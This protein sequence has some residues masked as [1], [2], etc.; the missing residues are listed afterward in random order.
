MRTGINLLLALIMLGGTVVMAQDATAPTGNN[1]APAAKPKLQRRIG[2]RLS[3][4][5]QAM[6]KKKAAPAASPAPTSTPPAA[7]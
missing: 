6:H 7:N 2:H 4:L 1:A 5:K 3:K